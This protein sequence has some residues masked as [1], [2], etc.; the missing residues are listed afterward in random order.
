MG[1][2]PDSASLEAAYVSFM[3]TPTAAVT[4]A[5]RCGAPRSAASDAGLARSE[6]FAQRIWPVIDVRG[7][8][9]VVAARQEAAYKRRSA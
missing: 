6:A 7:R 5:P 3:T 4:A 9:Q 2:D 8:I 1:D